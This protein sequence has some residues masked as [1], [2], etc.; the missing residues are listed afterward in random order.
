MWEDAVEIRETF[1]NRNEWIDYL[2]KNSILYSQESIEALGKQIIANGAEEPLT[3]FAAGAS[4]LIDLNGNWREGLVFHGINSR[5]RAVMLEIADAIDATDRY[6]PRIYAAEG[7]TAF[8]LRMRGIFPRFIGSEYTEEAPKREWLFPIPFEDLQNLSY[9]ENIFDLVSTNEVL[10]HVPSIDVAMSE[11]FRVLKPGAWHIGTCP[12]AF[13]SE[14]SIVRAKMS[15]GQIKHLMEP[16]Y[17]GNPMSENGSLVFEIPGWNIL[18][19]LRSIGFSKALMRFIVSARYGCLS[20]D[21]TGIFV[22]CCQK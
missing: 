1:T 19:R 10:E 15:N 17:H 9:P 21:I 14:E 22:L 3:G 16:E 11:I 12:F 20:T 8:A 13:M 7:L 6:N 4:D 2:D 5:T 18:Q